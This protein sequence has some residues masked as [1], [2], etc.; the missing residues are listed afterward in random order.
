VAQRVVVQ[1][2]ER[3][4]RA[5]ARMPGLDGWE[6]ARRAKEM[7]AEIKVL[8]ITGYPG[9]QRPN[10]APAGGEQLISSDDGHRSGPQP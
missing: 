10:D 2:R 9:E 6:L 5:V 1:D 3:L 7:R 4:P 8:Y